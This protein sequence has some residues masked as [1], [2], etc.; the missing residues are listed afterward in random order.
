MKRNNYFII[1]NEKFYCE[2]INTDVFETLQNHLMKDPS[3]K[4][5][6]ISD[7][8]FVHSQEDGGNPAI[9][10]TVIDVCSIQ[11]IQHMFD[12]I[13]RWASFNHYFLL[14]RYYVSSSVDYPLNVI[15]VQDYPEHW[16]VF[17][18]YIL[19]DNLS[20]VHSSNDSWI[21]SVYGK[22]ISNATK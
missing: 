15:I 5:S 8:Q 1:N 7:M 16:K 19:L 3:S 20:Y 13:I 10:V 12:T 17:E 14:Q 22:Q 9:I 6:I 11:Q 2:I 4:S 18:N 21:E